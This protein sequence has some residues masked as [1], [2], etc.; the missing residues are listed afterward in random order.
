MGCGSSRTSEELNKN[1]KATLEAL[2]DPFMRTY[3]SLIEQGVLFLDYT[4]LNKN[5]NYKEGE[6]IPMIG[7]V[8]VFKLFKGKENVSKY[9]SKGDKVLKLRQNLKKADKDNELG[10]CYLASEETLVLY[11]IFTTTTVTYEE[12]LVQIIASNKLQG[13]KT[14]ELN[15][16]LSFALLLKLINAVKLNETVKGLNVNII[17]DF[18][19]HSLINNITTQCSIEKLK[20]SKLGISGDSLILLD[21]YFKYNRALNKLKI[22]KNNLQ[23]LTS[24]K[25][26][27][28]NIFPRLRSFNISQNKISEFATIGKVINSSG[29]I[30]KLN[31]SK[32]QINTLEDFNTLFNDVGRFEHLVTLDLSFNY[33]NLKFLSEL[34]HKAKNLRKL[35]INKVKCDHNDDEVKEFGRAYIT[36]NLETL[37]FNFNNNEHNKLFFQGFGMVDATQ[38]TFK[39]KKIK[40]FKSTIDV[41]TCQ[42][43]FPLISTLDCF[44]ELDLSYVNITD[45]D[46]MT[47]NFSDLKNL[48]TLNVSNSELNDEKLT[49][50]GSLLLKNSSIKYLDIEKNSFANITKEAMEGFCQNLSKSASVG[51]LNMNYTF[52]SN[53]EVFIAFCEHLKSEKITE[54]SLENCLFPSDSFGEEFSKFLGNNG[55]IK[56]LKLGSKDEIFK[57]NSNNLVLK[58]LTNLKSLEDFS[59]TNIKVHQDSLKEFLT[60]SPLKKLH[61]DNVCVNTNFFEALPTLKH[62]QEISMT[63]YTLNSNQ[64]AAFVKTLLLNNP[65]LE[66]L[67]L[68]VPNITCEQLEIIVEGLKNNKAIRIFDVFPKASSLSS[69]YLKAVQ[70]FYSHLKTCT[71]LISLPV[72]NVSDVPAKIVELGTDFEKYFI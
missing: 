12:D 66:S 27:L 22:D 23:T 7:G 10:I 64:H 2:T 51:K 61:L 42:Q 17:D 72:L 59:F 36:S 5:G 62:L 15:D 52:E 63:V 34:L 1:K 16:H 60:N 67:I 39:S 21:N 32:V 40:L 48:K 4:D 47:T 35:V 6:Q 25:D 11:L 20:C 53:H 68:A 44:A 46:S 28:M 24:I 65:K 43:L 31:L 8:L 56:I 29:N 55:K 49:H 57:M 38:V 58:A 50:L 45:Y 33:V 54:L 13:L 9:L 14:L 69:D 18:L 26:V 37:L 71:G 3:Y 30:Q 70:V 19:L 41:T